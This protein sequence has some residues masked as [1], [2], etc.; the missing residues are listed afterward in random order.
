MRKQRDMPRGNPIPSIVRLRNLRPSW[1]PRATLS[2]LTD[3]PNVL[4]FSD[5]NSGPSTPRWR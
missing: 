3:P 5:V 1:N 2:A 4:A